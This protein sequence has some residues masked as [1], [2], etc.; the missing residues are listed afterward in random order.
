M[1][2]YRFQNTKR[3]IFPMKCGIVLTDCFS[4]FD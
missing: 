1:T 3:N 2:Y 4:T